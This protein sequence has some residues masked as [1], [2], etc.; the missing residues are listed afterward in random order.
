MALLKRHEASQGTFVLQLHFT[1]WRTFLEVRKSERDEQVASEVRLCVKQ[2]Y[3][4]SI[5]YFCWPGLFELKYTLAVCSIINKGFS[6]KVCYNG[7][8]ALL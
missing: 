2:S 3:K 6:G 4:I 7:K 1:Q 8:N 5:V